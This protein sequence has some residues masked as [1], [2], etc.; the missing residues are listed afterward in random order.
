MTRSA[1][2]ALALAGAAPPAFA[3]SVQKGEA[4]AQESP[5]AGLIAPFDRLR[6]RAT[7]AGVTLSARYTS[8]LGFNVAGGDA[9]RVT[10]TGQADVGAK[11]D[12]GQVAG[13]QG[14]TLNAVVTWRRGHLLDSTANLGTLQQTQEVYGRGQTWRLTRLWYEQAL[15]PVA[16]KAGRSNV[17]EDFAT[18][19]CDFMNL[20]FCGAQPG[21]IVG[22]YWYNWPVS[23]WMARAKLSIGQGY[24]QLGAYEVNPRNL[25]KTFTIGYLHGATG[26]LLPVEGVWKPK[27]GGLPGTWRAGAWYDTSH[28]D[29]VALDRAGGLAAAGGLGPLRREGRWGGWAIVRQQVTG[30]ADEDGA[31]RG[32]TLFGRV[33]Q[34]DRR[35]ARIDSQVTVGLFYEGLP[36]LASDDVLGAAL[37]RTHVNHRVE[38]AQR[39]RGEAI[40]G[41]EWTGE[42]FYSLH[43]AT[44]LVLRPNVQ[45]ILHPGGLKH[46]SDAVVLGLKSAFTL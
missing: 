20:S 10:E 8:E 33:T 45:Y 32:L 9:E 11:L 12:M 42:V 22:D 37:G 44:G 21:N 38:A 39:I 5:P 19:S 30:A 40:Q 36:G 34:A 41:A 35:T 28:A 6:G 24:V 29:D 2:L 3:Q 25:R 26:V 4:D 46:R 18:F 7:K 1:L 14:G 15:G 16:L 23:Q 31:V 43:P 17:G 27:V 13:L